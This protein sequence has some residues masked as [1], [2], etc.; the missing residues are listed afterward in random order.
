MVQLG[1]LR[2]WVSDCRV[3][4]GQSD[5]HYT[6]SSGVIHLLVPVSAM[7]AKIYESYWFR[8]TGWAKF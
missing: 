1:K 5:D 8:A 7:L 3:N 2:V 6:F 4:V